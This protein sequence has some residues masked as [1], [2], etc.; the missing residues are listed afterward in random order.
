M[1]PAYRR[2]VVGLDLHPE[3]G[4]LTAGGRAALAQARWL[5]RGESIR[6]TLLH[7]TKAD[8]FW[9]GDAQ[10]YRS[11]RA[12]A[13]SRDALDSA[14][15]ELE[16]AGVATEVEVA[17]ERAWLAIVRRVIEAPAD[18]VIVGKRTEHEPG[19]PFVGSQ[20]TKLLRNC[21]CAVWVARPGA[22]APPTCV[23][24]ATDL[25]AVGE[26]VLQRAAF[27]AERAGAILHVL[28]TLQLTMAAQLHADDE[29]YLERTEDETRAQ[30]HELLTRIGYTG[31][32]ELHIGLTTPTRGVLECVARCTPDLVVLGTVSR[33]GVAGLLLGNT[34]ERLLQR[35]DASLLTIKPADFVC[36]VELE[37]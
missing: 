26:R 16:G 27:V 18:L 24:A 8:E 7:S 6:C 19:G 29:G 10:V 22:P 36:P 21:P 17:E 34:A 1:E 13:P 33:G 31:R 2:I 28:H 35:I 5:A 3:S 37:E 4:A 15:A 9:D 23:L 12:A 14:R 20:A 30:I 11:A 25:S 32:P